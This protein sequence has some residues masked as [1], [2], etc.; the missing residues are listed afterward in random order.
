MENSTI[1]WT[2]HTFNG[3]RGCSK[4]SDGCRNCY[5]EK[6]SKRNPGVLGEWGAHGTRVIASEAQWKLPLKW[7]RLAQ[8]S[9]RKRVFCAS[10]GDVFEDRPELVEPRHRLFNLIMETPYLDWLLLTKRP[11]NMQGMIEE[12]VGHM[13]E[14]YADMW[15]HCFQNVWLGTSVENQAAADQRIPK[16]LEVPAALHFLSCEP[17]LGM[18]DLSPWL[19]ACSACEEPVKPLSPQWRMGYEG[20]EHR[21]DD[22][23]PQC[24][25]FDVNIHNK[26]VDWVIVGGESG[27]KARPML[28]DW[29]RSLRDQCSDAGVP[30]FM[31]Q[32]GEWLPFSHGGSGEPKQHYIDSRNGMG[33]SAASIHRVGKKKAGRLLDGREHNDVP[34]VYHD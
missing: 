34:Q 19:Y 5:A 18:V 33:Q 22:A 29:A 20:W 26:G 7:D 11:E 25:H 12:T 9:G 15:P 6:M 30:Y 28:P 31:K 16:L 14:G 8:V 23:H 17:L 4:V 32:W 3:W 24:G 13:G 10:L 21:C 27:A 1:E 2:H